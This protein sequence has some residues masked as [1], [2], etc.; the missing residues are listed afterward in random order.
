M[1]HPLPDQ[2][3]Y[4][5][6]AYLS[7]D[8]EWEHR[9]EYEHGQLIDRGQTFD[10]HSELMINIAALLKSQTRGRG[11]KV[12]AETVSLEIEPDGVYYLPDVMLTC[13]P[14]DL[15]D[16]KI[17]RHPLLVVEI[18]SEGSVQRD[19]DEKFRAYLRLPGLRY[20]MLVA[21][22]QVR[23]EVFAKLE[24]SRGWRFD[25]FDDLDDVIDLT[26]IGVSL[27]VQAVYDEVDLVGRG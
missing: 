7:L 10:T 9:Y 8:P 22:D 18:L 23:I 25:Y 16:R 15:E 24:D 6:E 5:P 19:R 1:A 3:H 26:E 11:C 2:R 14:R 27:P 21:Q 13:D 4:S 20:Y 17:K 12:Y